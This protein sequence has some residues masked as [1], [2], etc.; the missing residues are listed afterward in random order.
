MIDCLINYVVQFRK[1]VRESMQMFPINYHNL[2]S[3]NKE[4]I[5]KRCTIYVRK[6]IGLCVNG[7]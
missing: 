6:Y 3:C 5:I 7:M 2:I 4:N 1:S